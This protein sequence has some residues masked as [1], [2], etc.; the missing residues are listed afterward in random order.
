MFIQQGDILFFQDELPQGAKALAQ[1]TI[2]EGEHTGHAHV[3]TKAATLF[4]FGGVLF[5]CAEDETQVTHQEHGTVTLGPGTWRVG[6]VQEFDP[7]AEL[8]RN[9]AD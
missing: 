9:V 7:F 2:A 4:D 6:R 8:V 3:A 5:V 1:R